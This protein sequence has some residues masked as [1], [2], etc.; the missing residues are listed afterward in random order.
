VST[1]ITARGG[2]VTIT[3]TLVLGYAT[4]QTSS[5]QLHLALGATYPGATTRQAIARSGTLTLL[6]ATEADADECRYEHA[7]PGT[8]TLATTDLA[9]AD[10]VYVPIGE[11]TMK[12]D[13][14]TYNAWIVETGYQEVSP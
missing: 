10:M 2:L 12:L 3:P 8:L 11:V 7:Q 4:A 9:T 13:D 1:T 6:F 5:T 14:T